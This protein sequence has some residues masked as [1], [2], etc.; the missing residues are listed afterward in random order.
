[1]RYILT[2]GSYLFELIFQCV[3]DIF[4]A[5][6]RK[7]EAMII[8]SGGLLEENTLSANQYY[9]AMRYEYGEG[10]EANTEKA[11]EFYTLAANQ[12]HPDAQFKLAQ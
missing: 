3:K 10:V 6:Q 8:R 1:M 5:F 11:V 2:L 7:D 12:G 9:L 4:G